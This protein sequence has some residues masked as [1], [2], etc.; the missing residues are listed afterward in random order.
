[1]SAPSECGGALI[2]SEEESQCGSYCDLRPN[3]RSA[4]IGNRKKWWT[5]F[6]R[7]AFENRKYT[8]TSNMKSKT[9]SVLIL[10]K[11]DREITK[12]ILFNL[13]LENI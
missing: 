4:P 7:Q 13:I 6:K 12:I 10:Q 11:Q 8:Y 1:M 3:L 2:L 9:F 5:L